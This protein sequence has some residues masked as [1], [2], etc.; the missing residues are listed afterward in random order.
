MDER[1]EEVGLVKDE[2]VLKEKEED[3]NY[4]SSNNNIGFAPP[5]VMCHLPLPCSPPTG[6][7]SVVGPRTT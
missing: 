1:G 4:E 2:R 6:P 7:H 3:G 5:S